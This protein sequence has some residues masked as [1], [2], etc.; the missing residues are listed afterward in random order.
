VIVR[1]T[2]MKSVS[3]SELVSNGATRSIV[4]VLPDNC[5]PSWQRM[6]DDRNYKVRSRQSLHASNAS[7]STHACVGIELKLP[8]VVVHGAIDQ[9][10]PLRMCLTLGYRHSRSHSLALISYAAC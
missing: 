3:R 1:L 4:R 7:E 5:M 6:T 10:L 8:T 2:L 9:M